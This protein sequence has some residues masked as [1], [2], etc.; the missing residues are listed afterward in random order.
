MTFGYKVITGG[1]HAP[2]PSYA[3]P[4]PGPS[5]GRRPPASPSPVPGL[6][7]Q[8]LGPSPLVA[9]AGRRRPDHL[10]V[11]RLRP[12]PRRPLRRDGAPGP[13]G[14]PARL[15]RAAAPAQRRPGRAPA[16]GAAQAPSAT[17]HRPDVDPLPRPTVP[18]P[19]GD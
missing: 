10:A 9:P 8:D 19:R 16:Q 2:E 13:A 14:D 4:Q 15:R 5:R 7:A 6:Q 11:R 18:G 1:S 12:A 17:G 3:R